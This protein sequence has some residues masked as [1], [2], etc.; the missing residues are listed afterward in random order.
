[1]LFTTSITM[2]NKRLIP[3]LICLLA[4]FTGFAQT[5]A[6]TNATPNTSNT[7][8]TNTSV[9]T[10]DSAKKQKAVT[11]IQVVSVSKY[12]KKKASNSQDTISNIFPGDYLIVAFNRKDLDTVRKNF[13]QYRLWID[14]ILSLI[15]IS[16]G[17]VR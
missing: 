3:Y 10:T 11:T 1:M 12:F 8:S 4:V 13:T 17:I 7:V 9:N 6:G 15:H 5:P 2:K 14:G 16:Q